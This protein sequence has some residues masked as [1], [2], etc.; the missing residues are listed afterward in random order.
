MYKKPII[1][2]FEIGKDK[3]VHWFIRFQDVFFGIALIA[4]GFITLGFGVALLFAGNFSAGII[5]AIVGLI[6]FL[7]FFFARIKG[8]YGL[9][10][11][12]VGLVVLASG[13]I[14]M[15]YSGNIVFANIL[16]MVF[17]LIACVLFRVKRG[18]VLS[19]AM[20]T[21][22]FV[23]G[24]ISGDSIDT[25][26]QAAFFLAGI[27]ILIAVCG[28]I[29]ITTELVVSSNNKI[30]DIQKE[31]D[32]IDKFIEQLSFQI[33]TPLNNIIGIGSLLNSTQLNQRQK[34]WLETIIASAN[35]L[36]SVVNIFSSSVTSVRIDLNK[37]VNVPFDLLSTMNNIIQTYVGHSPDYNI[38]MKPYMETTNILEGDPIQIKQIFMILIDTIIANKKAEKINIIISIRVKQETEKLY[39]VH[40][41]IR[42][43]DHYE[44]D[45]DIDRNNV[46][47][48]N[49][50]IASRSIEM[51][52]NKLNV[53]YDNKFT[54]FTFKLSFNKSTQTEL[55][56]IHTVTSQK[57]ESDD[58][59]SQRD[60]SK[61][62]LREAN[63]LLVEDNLINQ[64]IV[65][66]SIKNLVKNIDIANNGLEAVNKFGSSKYHIILMDLQMPVMDG[67][68]A[69]QKI[70]AIELEKRV[71]PTPIIAITA[72]ALA[73]DREH[74]LAS[75]MDEYIS[76]P[77]QVEV[78]VTKMKNLLAMSSPMHN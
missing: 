55:K 77:F 31:N 52:G 2:F 22:C 34:D 21:T 1:D 71:V 56:E 74:C 67:I 18:S 23:V 28:F 62:D 14:F 50:S 70:R 51:T 63:V 29:V 49:F 36:V 59:A 19:V 11:S 44:F 53:T 7:I 43:S 3:T 66:L 26:T 47:M 20:F 32:I 13:I 46:E 78:L 72:N 24:L 39:D 69:T 15:L 16:S 37:G 17:P 61:I 57:A 10:L 41:E 54:S 58:N 9:I 48:F 8:T 38:G 25:Q 68:Q 60:L 76:K 5:L 12:L 4:G 73:G 30:S 6:N 40:F 33:R 75:G 65:I 27:F 45:V 64:K 42:V 35:N